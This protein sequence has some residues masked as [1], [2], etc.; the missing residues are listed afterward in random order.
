MLSNDKQV[1][2]QVDVDGTLHTWPTP[3]KI[4]PTSKENCS[5]P[6]RMPE[7]SRCAL[8]QSC[9]EDGA[10]ESM[11]VDTGVFSMTIISE[12]MRSGGSLLVVPRRHVTAFMDLT[13]SEASEMM[14]LVRHAA[15]NIE[16]ALNPD[17]LHVWTD[18]GLAAGQSASHMCF[19]VVPRYESL[20]YH[21]VPRIHLPNSPWEQRFLLLKVLAS[22]YHRDCR[23]V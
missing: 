17:G 1:V 15:A 7:E 11:I 13:E 20:E 10:R 2:S 14:V 8:C 9:S 3:L 21:Y 6:Y 22:I 18:I 16:K 19:E 23:L 5:M 12:Q 4:A